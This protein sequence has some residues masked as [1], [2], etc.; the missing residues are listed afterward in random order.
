MGRKKK[1]PFTESHVRFYRH[2]LQSVA[3]QTLNP[4]ARALLVELRS[5]YQPSQGNLVFLSVREAMV[6]LGIGQR[7]AQA[8]FAALLDRC[9][10]KV[11]TV[12]GF[13]RKT[14]HATSFRLEN[15]PS[16]APGAVASKGYMRWLP[17]ADH[18]KKAR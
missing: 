9:W 16:S 7:R 6:R 11:E 5:L 3:W 4:D 17:N 2:E 8:A 13:Q 12:G 15:D 14:R 18:E 1:G 10:I